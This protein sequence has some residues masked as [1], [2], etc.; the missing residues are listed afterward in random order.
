MNPF[1]ALRHRIGWSAQ[2]VA[3]LLCM[4][5][6]QV[7]RWDSGDASPPPRVLAWMER[8]KAALEV[9]PPPGKTDATE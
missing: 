2:H 6:R 8:V 4:S 9:L 5:E 1:A 7:R 3:D